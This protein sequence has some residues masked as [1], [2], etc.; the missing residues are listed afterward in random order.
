MVYVINVLILLEGQVFSVRSDDLPS[1][2]T[3]VI[4]RGKRG[5]TMAT[6]N[7]T[8]KVK[9]KPV[10]PRKV[11]SNI[12]NDGGKMSIA[13][14]GMSSVLSMAILILIGGDVFAGARNITAQS[15]QAWFSGVGRIAETED[16]DTVLNNPA[17]AA[18]MDDGVHIH[19]STYIASN[20]WDVTDVNTGTEY[21]TE[22][23]G[24]IPGFAL[25]YKKNN[26]AVFQTV[27][28]PGGNG[29]GDYDRYPSFDYAADV[30][31][32]LLGQT[33]TAENQK[34][35]FSGGKGAISI[36]G[37]WAINDMV[38]VGYAIRAVY[39]SSFIDAEATLINQDAGE[40]IEHVR[41]DQE[42]D[43]LGL[44]HSLCV[45]FNNDAFKLGLRF[46][47]E[48]K[49]QKKVDV[50]PGDNS[51]TVNGSKTHDDLPAALLLGASYQLTP[52]FKFG[53]G[54]VYYLQEGI[55]GEDQPI[56]DRWDN[57]WEVSGFV[58]YAL[59]PEWELLA[60]V[61]YTYQGLPGEVYTLADISYADGWCFQAGTQWRP[62]PHWTYIAGLTHTYYP[63]NPKTEGDPMG[64]YERSIGKP[65]IGLVL[66][67]EYKR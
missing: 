48:V 53:G 57:A 23:L 17:G 47:P 56:T 33:V 31:S 26:W 4:N 43:G 25:T 38:S 40:E 2:K 32:S 66:G 12:K 36:G 52:K 49:I 64:L 54:F 45:L 46:D 7:K 50:K 44:G 6:T 59:T 63:N 1:Y 58:E 20:V 11:L 61:S 8:G 22:S 27:S 29:S 42:S 3:E 55:N 18:Y 62:S 9:I 65:V 16:A 60:G 67:I 51:G 15:G 34:F 39:A 41:I 37:A 19:F 30:Y 24:S 10:T 5:K 35:E 14:S 21:E 13:K 28:F